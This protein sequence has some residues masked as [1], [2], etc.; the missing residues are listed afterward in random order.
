MT[1]TFLERASA[2]YEAFVEHIPDFQ[3]MGRVEATLGFVEGLARLAWEA[4]PGRYADGKVENLLLQIG[5][6]LEALVESPDLA[7]N[8]EPLPVRI[9]GRRHFLHVATEIYAVG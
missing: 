4:H 1:R 2:A 6:G 3:D 7:T 8:R 9:H 5:E